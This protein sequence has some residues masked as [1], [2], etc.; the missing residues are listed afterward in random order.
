[1]N[2]AE[3]S[4]LAYVGAKPGAKRDSDSWFTPAEYIESARAALGRID[5]DPYSSDEANAVVQARKY[6]TVDSPNPTIGAAWPKVTSVWMNPPYSGGAAREAA[7]RFL[8]AF[9]AGR[10]VRGI[11][12]VNNATETRMFRDLAAKASAICFTDHRIAFYNVDGK[13]VSGNTRGQAFLYF[14]HSD[15]PSA[16][17]RE[18]RKHGYTVRSLT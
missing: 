1:M 10:F 13:K 4:R 8:S 14:D 9:E 11:V 7:N 3:K 2:A 12:L 5:Y 6:S 15:D 17:A 16:F 18:F